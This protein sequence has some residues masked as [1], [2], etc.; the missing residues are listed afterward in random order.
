MKINCYYFLYFV[1]HIP[2]TTWLMRHFTSLHVLQRSFCISSPA[3]DIPAEEWHV[4]ICTARLMNLSGTLIVM[5]FISHYC[6]S[7]LL[8]QFLQVFI[9]GKRYVLTDVEISSSPPV[10]SNAGS[11]I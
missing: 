10:I 7:K 5:V 4:F 2:E 8:F 9:K 11:V 1:E 6:T 3:L